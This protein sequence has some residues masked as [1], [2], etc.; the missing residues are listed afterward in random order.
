MKIDS[1]NS[2]EVFDLLIEEAQRPLQG[3]DFS[4]INNRVI[5]APLTWSYHTEILKYIRNVD[6]LLDMGTGGGEFL[7]LLEPF[8]EKAFATEAYEPNFPIAK[9]RLEPLG[10]K[11][12]QI[13]GDENLPFEDES[14]ELIINRHESYS[15]KE[16]YRILSKEGIFLT[17]QV[18]GTNDNWLREFLLGDAIS[19]YQDWNL[20]F[21]KNVLEENGFKI[22]QKME[23]FPK[24][25]IFD[26]GAIV[27]YLQA[28]PWEVPDFTV[29]KYRDRLFELHNTISNKGYIE[30]ASHRFLIKATK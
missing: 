21:A 26:I 14:F 24:K 12:V 15:P 2:D 22:V 11:V 3:W 28:A 17:Q 1:E 29:E 8:P 18:G 6:S 23:C 25:R 30:Y 20:E 13:D 10:V 16:V 27:F 4:Y 9:N 5:S 7:S 19:E